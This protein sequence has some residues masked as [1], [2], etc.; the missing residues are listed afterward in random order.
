MAQPVPA[1]FQHARRP[2]WGLA[3]LAWE[4]DGKRAY[5]FEGGMLKVLAEPFFDLM[6]PTTEPV[7]N[8]ASIVQRLAKHLE[9][10]EAIRSSTRAT[11]PPNVSL[12]DQ[13]GLFRAE[14]EGDFAGS[15][16]QEKVRGLGQQRRLK[17]HRN[18]AIENAR[19]E[20]SKEKL[21]SFAQEKQFAE[22]FLALADVIGAT[23]LA[24]PKQVEAMRNRAERASLQTV[25]VL[26]NLLHG[27]GA[28]AD[29]FLSYLK[30]MSRI[31]GTSPSWEIATAVLALVH[32]EVHVCVRR[33]SF[34]RQAEWR[35]APLG[36]TARPNAASYMSCLEMANS[37][38]EDLKK[39]DTKPEDLLDIHDFI[40]LTTTPSAVRRMQAVKRAVSKAGSDD[41][42]QA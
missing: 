5:L 21:D 24:A 6:Q 1:F 38:M 41:E 37:L 18:A 34:Q 2:E 42:A 10:N 30:E 32:P 14:Y 16:W 12:E 20:L 33:T 13:L 3:V 15:E 28:F 36:N 26:T 35:M 7:E 31:L 11:I 9:A 22:A 23:D 40:K 25:Q 39:A 29:C 8:G 27:D 19:S 4:R 17:R